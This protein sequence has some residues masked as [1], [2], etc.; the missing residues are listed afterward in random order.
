MK[1]IF[2]LLL[3]GCLAFS[4]ASYVPTK[5]P[6]QWRRD[7]LEAKP[8]HSG[9][10]NLPGASKNS[11]GYNKDFLIKSKRY[12]DQLE[13]EKRAAAFD[14]AQIDLEKRRNLLVGRYGFRIGKRSEEPEDLTERDY[15]DL[16]AED[17]SEPEQVTISPENPWGDFIQ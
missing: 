14:N 15:Q 16:V 13:K 2:L 9:W 4:A 3:L 8:T 1:P 6:D 7:I 5:A 17:S 10:M 11:H 12:V